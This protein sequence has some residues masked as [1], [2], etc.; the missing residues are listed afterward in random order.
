MNALVGTQVKRMGALF[1][2]VWLLRRFYG[3][4]VALACSAYQR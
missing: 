3:F 4:S 1:L 2:R